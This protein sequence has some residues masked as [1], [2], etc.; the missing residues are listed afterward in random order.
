[1]TSL[2]L[3]HAGAR[4]ELVARTCEAAVIE[5]RLGGLAALQRVASSR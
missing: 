5:R 2:P 3:G 4:T 1:M